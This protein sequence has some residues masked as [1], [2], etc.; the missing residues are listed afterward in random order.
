MLG[1]ERLGVQS[2]FILLMLLVSLGSIFAVGFLGY[3]SAKESLTRAVQ[4]HLQSVRHSK[5][6]ALMTLLESLRDQVISL[7][8]SK[9]VSEAMTRFK[10]ARGRLAGAAPA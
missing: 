1:L 6:A 2:R 5:T 9:L 10:E 8:D 3:R 4:N 7:S